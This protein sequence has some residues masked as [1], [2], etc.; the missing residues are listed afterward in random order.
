[1]DQ[2]EQLVHLS[3][4]QGLEGQDLRDFVREEQDRIKADQDSHCG[5][6]Q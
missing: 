1:M 5:E 3:K 6:R 2:L 4:E